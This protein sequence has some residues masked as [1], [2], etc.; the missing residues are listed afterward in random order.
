[1]VKADVKAKLN[2]T[3]QNPA[4]IRQREEHDVYMNKTFPALSP[5]VK[6]KLAVCPARWEAKLKADL[7]LID[8]LSRDDPDR[9]V[10]PSFHEVFLQRIQYLVNNA[11]EEAARAR[12]AEEQRLRRV[13][14]ELGQQGTSGEHGVEEEHGVHETGG[15]SQDGGSTAASDLEREDRRREREKG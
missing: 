10:I 3:R 7:E 12:R 14:R 8:N 15:E 13:E 6:E 2:S 9:Q 11:Q 5:S 4:A 1:M